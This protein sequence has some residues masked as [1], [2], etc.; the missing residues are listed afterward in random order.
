MTYCR[1]SL[2][3]GFNI[4]QQTPKCKYLEFPSLKVPEL[5]SILQAVVGKIVYL[6]ILVHDLVRFLRGFGQ[7]GLE[8]EAKVQY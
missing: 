7:K 6:D 1:K 5:N 3:F 2:D 8:M 4:F